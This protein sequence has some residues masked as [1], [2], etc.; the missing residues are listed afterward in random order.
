ML[1]GPTFNIEI[2]LK[3]SVQPL[4]TAMRTDD[5]PFHQKQHS[6]KA[7]LIVKFVIEGFDS[8]GVNPDSIALKLTLH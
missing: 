7:E 1:H 5:H 6:R 3:S 8:I 2:G 4:S